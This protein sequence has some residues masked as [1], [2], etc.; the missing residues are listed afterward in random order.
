MSLCAIMPKK[1]H[2]FV[3]AKTETFKI[4]YSVTKKRPKI[5]HAE[6]IDFAAD[7]NVDTKAS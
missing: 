2:L 6:L 7:M 3:D 4:N 1:K 5:K